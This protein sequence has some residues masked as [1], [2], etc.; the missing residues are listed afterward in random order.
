[1]FDFNQLL[2]TFV[3]SA[4]SDTTKSRMSHALGDS[5][6]G[7]ISGLGDLLGN[8]M[9]QGG[10]QST[11]VLG[12]LGRM[13]GQ[14]L[15]GGSTSGQNS[16]MAAGIEALG[17]ALLGTGPKSS[18]KSALAGS[19]M[20]MLAGLA[21]SALQNMNRQPE[22]VAPAAVP[23][24]LRAPQTQE[25]TDSLQKD[26]KTILK[27]MINA[28]KADGR[29][30]ETESQRIVSKLQEGGADDA[31]MQFVLAEMKKP[32]DLQGILNRVSNREMAAQ[33]YAASLLA[34][35]VDT[36]EEAAYMNRLAEGMG[37]SQAE[38]TRLHELL[39]V[40]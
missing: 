13:A 19:A 21:I 27:A 29:V 5:G 6:L 17:S 9:G 22:A 37:L 26:A 35:K 23:L 28:A 36:P 14:F 33:V 11:G 20:T 32:F 3:R 1:M 25:E 30:D 38:V 15:G 40:N 12:D 16:M 31:A 10:G 39:G 7:G 34:I 18:G 24:G 2:D 8:V 4:T